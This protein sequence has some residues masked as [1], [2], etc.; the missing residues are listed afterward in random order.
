VHSIFLDETDAKLRELQR[1]NGLQPDG[2][3]GPK[4]WAAL[5]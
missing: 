1:S 4:T 3:V 5:S 2:I